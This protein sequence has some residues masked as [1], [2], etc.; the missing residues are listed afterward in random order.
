MKR[1]PYCGTDY[2]DEA[3]KCSKDRTPLDTK[4]T[5]VEASAPPPVSSNGQLGLANGAL[6]LGILAVVLSLFLIGGLFAIAAVGLGWM[7]LAKNRRP[8]GTARW[9]V[10]LGIVGLIA[11]LGMGAVYLSVYKQ[12]KVFMNSAASGEDNVAHWEGVRAPELVLTTLDGTRIK[13]SEFKGKRIVL[14]FWATWCPPCRKEI[15]HF[16]KLYNETSRDKLVIIGVSDESPLTLKKFVR[17]N[18][19]PYPIANGTNL[20]APYKSISSIPTTFFIDGKGTIQKIAIGYHDYADIK[21]EALAEDFQ[22]EV[23]DA[24]VGPKPLADAAVKL[25]AAQL[26]FTNISGAH[27]LCAG[28]WTNEGEAQILVA[29]GSTLHVLNLVGSELAVVNLPEKFEFFECG[30]NKVQGAR[31]LGYEN[32]GQAV[33]IM[34]GR[35]TKLWEVKAGSGID[36][37]HWGDLDGDGTDE[38]I[39]GMNGGAGL[40][41]WSSDGKKMWTAK[42][43][44]VWNQAVIPAA[45]GQSAIVL[46]TEAGGTV[47]TFDATGRLLQS[48]RPGGGY[49][50]QMAAC[51]VGNAIQIMAINGNDTFAFDENGTVAWTTSAISDHAG[52][53]K[54]SFV[55]GDLDGDGIPDWV[56]IDGNGDLVIANSRGEKISA[57][58]DSKSLERFIV[59]P[60]K[61]KGGL[62]VTLSGQKLT[63]YEFSR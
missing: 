26:W 37:A 6:V 20:A 1:C 44:N 16:V 47:K 4:P 32:W 7:Y 46:A 22:G 3:I 27:A 29:A 50:A 63:V 10:G 54:S 33:T 28:A 42:L 31:L 8:T 19:I 12:V 55:S 24:P 39:V 2:P 53:R 51:R 60:R 43:G 15:P 17:E 41:A 52:W 56:F 61:E 11:S 58:P 35:G 9:G 38:L 18:G 36:G 30:R 34:D 49:F 21:T 5:V 59:V 48:L 25:K 13:L 14:D 45:P 40:Q 62:L 23:K 57:I